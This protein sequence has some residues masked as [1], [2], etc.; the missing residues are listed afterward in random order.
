MVNGIINVYKEAG[1]TS[2]DVV[3]RL[4]GIAGQK[5]IGHTG[6]LDP[7]ATGVLPVCL[8]NA[9]K[10]CEYLTDKTKEYEAGF[11][12]GIETDTQDISGKVTKES[13]VNFADIT[14]DKIKTVVSDFKGRQQQIPPMYSAVKV[15]GKRLYELARNGIE[16]ERK[17]RD[18]EVY[19]IE[20]LSVKD[21][22]IGIRVACSKG[23]YIRT[24]IYDI[25]RKLGCG[26]TMT[27]LKRTRS[28]A[29]SIDTSLKLNRLENIFK[30]EDEL[31]VR[32]IITPVDSVFSEYPALTVKDEEL[33]RV[34]NGNY[35]NHKQ[36]GER[37]RIY[38][39]EDRFL[40]LYVYN[41][42]DRRYVPEKMF[43]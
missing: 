8:G 28:G 33:K 38:D 15:D 22:D 42:H 1:Y 9:T 35:V 13:Y 18:I 10:L 36:I 20:V 16:V 24:L 40:A 43:L 21:K 26:A 17:P 29:F 30:G 4:R 23:T 7:D 6:T 25:G 3:A 19:D 39:P 12:L 32:D 34:M 41:R 37:L 14:P 5:K 2:F 27:A 31:T 11:V